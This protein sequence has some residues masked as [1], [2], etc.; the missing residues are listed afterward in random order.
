[1]IKFSLYNTLS[2]RKINARPNFLI[3]IKVSWDQSEKKNDVSKL[4]VI[5]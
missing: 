5:I 3:L 1:M 2:V 4:D